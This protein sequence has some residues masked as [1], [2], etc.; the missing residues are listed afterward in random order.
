MKCN[1]KISIFIISLVLSFGCHADSSLEDYMLNSYTKTLFYQ[2]PSEMDLQ[3]ATELFKSALRNK[4]V[5]QQEL[6]SW[7]ELGFTVEQVTEGNRY[8]VISEFSGAKPKGYGFYVINVSGTSQRVLE[9]PHRPSDTYTHKIIYNLF[10]E[11]DY[12]AAAWN[13]THRENVDLAHQSSSYFNSFTMAVAMAFDNP[14]I[15]QLH[16]FDGA[17]HDIIGDMVF[18]STRKDPPEIYHQMANC[19]RG[20][21]KDSDVAFMILEYPS[22]IKDLGGTLN[23]NARSFYA[24]N[25]NAMFFHI[26]TSKLLRQHLKDNKTLRDSFSNCFIRQ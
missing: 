6:I 4:A 24:V 16:A 17:K 2:P 7:K 19:L 22:D 9:A 1:L 14:Q 3:K 12:A 20:G 5:T 26:E 8:I 11:G 23:I 15:I 13:T 21:L 18:S 10:K 25:P